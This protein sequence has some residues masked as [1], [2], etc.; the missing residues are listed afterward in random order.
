MDGKCELEEFFELYELENEDEEFDANTVG[1]WV[2]EKY[3][4][5]PPIGE[6]ITFKCI[7]LRIVKATKQKVLK[8]RSCKIEMAEEEED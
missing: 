6:T 5:I 8:V 4:G 2:T 7:E 1:G 3:G